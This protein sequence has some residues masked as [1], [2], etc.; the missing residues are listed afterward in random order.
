MGMAA[1]AGLVGGAI[2]F[3]LFAIGAMGAG[4]IKL[5][6]AVSLIAGFG[7]LMEMFAAI[8]MVGGAF[9][10]GLA[11]VRRRFKSTVANVGRLIHHHAATGLLPHPEL[12][13]LNSEALRMPYAIA[14]AGG[15]WIVL[16][17][18]IAMSY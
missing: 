3:L 5:M 15:C 12:N 18:Q 11:L 6:A 9:A 10:I 4:D 7:H 17:S 13:L 8:A 2:F 16:A 1:L 14:I